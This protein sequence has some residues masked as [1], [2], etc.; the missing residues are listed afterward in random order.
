MGVVA[1]Y[2]PHSVHDPLAGDH[3]RARLAAGMDRD[4]RDLRADLPAAAQA[5]QY[6]SSALGYAGVR[7]PSGGILVA[8]GSNVG[9]LS[10]GRLTAPRHSQ[11]DLQRH[12][13]VHA[14]R[15]RLHGHY[16]FLAGHDAVAAELPL[17]R[18]TLRH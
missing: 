14:D 5:L 6:R 4:H 12:D 15:D 13:A 8:A 11:P 18:L 10:Q 9:L 17:W 16:V 3:L 7:E 1:Q 2:D